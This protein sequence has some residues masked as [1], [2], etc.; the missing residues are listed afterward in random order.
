MMMRHGGLLKLDS[1]RKGWRDDS[2]AAAG[3]LDLAHRQA[4]ATTSGAGR[5]AAAQPAGPA[6]TR[7]E[8][9]AEDF[10][11]TPETPAGAEGQRSK[12]LTRT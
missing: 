1:I 10:D 11:P 7:P 8:L 2:G 5:V 9:R 6:G 4:A 3:G 12:G